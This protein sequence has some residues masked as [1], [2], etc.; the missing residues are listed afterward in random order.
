MTRKSPHASARKWRRKCGMRVEQNIHKIFKK[1]YEVMA[2]SILVKAN[3]TTHSVI[4]CKQ[5]MDLLNGEQLIAW[6]AKFKSLGVSKRDLTRSVNNAINEFAD[7]WHYKCDK[8]P[9][10]VGYILSYVA[11]YYEEVQNNPFLKNPQEWKDNYIN[12]H[13]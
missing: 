5:L 7:I 9:C 10:S 11:S 12:T 13:D 2:K 8:T 3:N 4:N 6:N 1:G